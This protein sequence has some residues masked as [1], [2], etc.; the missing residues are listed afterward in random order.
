ME[1]E[2]KSVKTNGTDEE[3]VTAGN[4][5]AQANMIPEATERDGLFTGQSSS[6]CRIKKELN[7]VICSPIRLWMVIIIIL[8]IIIAVIV[9]SL[10]LCSVI[11]TDLDEKYDAALFNIPQSFNGSFRLPNQV[12][13]EQLLTLNSSEGNALATGLQKK[14][15]DFYRSSPALGRYFSEAK[16][17]AFRNGSVIADY[18]LTFHMPAEGQYQLRNFTLSRE[19]VYNVFRQFLFD[20]ETTS[21][22]MYIDPRS[23][24]CSQ[25]Y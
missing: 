23:L 6:Q 15:V 8:V 3:R 16:I 1:Y 11:H 4:G 18:R 20:Q 9:I 25:T 14:M 5:G 21:E 13:K 2:L 7:A 10:V 24:N 12:F 17:N 22:P 19:M